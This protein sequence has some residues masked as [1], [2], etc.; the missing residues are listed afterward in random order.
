MA[1]K[2]I[3]I[4]ALLLIF[5]I[6][7]SPT[8][9]V[10]CGSRFPTAVFSL[11]GGPD[12]P[13]QDFL[14]GE[15][16]ILQPD[17][18]S[19]NLVPAY[20]YLTGVGLNAEEQQALLGETCHDANS[21]TSEKA[22][23]PEDWVQNW[24]D[25]RGRIKAAGAAPPIGWH[26][27]GSSS[28]YRAEQK[29]G[30]FVHY[31][32]CAEDAFKTAIATL[33]E[34]IRVFG[35]QGPEILDWIKAQDAVFSNCS[36]GSTIPSPAVPDDNPTLKADRA[37]QIAAAH[38]YAGDFEQAEK[39]F[40]EISQDNTSPWR[41]IAPYL[42]ARCQVR[43]GT[44]KG[45]FQKVE[46]A[47]MS[48]AEASLRAILENSNLSQYHKPAEDLL[49]YVVTR[50]RP[51]EQVHQT[52]LR[53]STKDAGRKMRQ[54][55][56]DFRYLLMNT[57]PDA[58]RAAREL[59]DLTDWV[60]TFQN[61]TPDSLEHSIERWEKTRSQ[62]WLIAAI[63]KIPAGHPK[64]QIVQA[65]A[66]KLHSTEPGYQTAI[67]HSL[68]LLIDSGE[69]DVAR[70]RLDI[71]LADA[72][73]K[74]TNSARNLLLGLRLQ[75]SNSL[76]EFL[77][78]SQR[79]P[80]TVGYGYDENDMDMDEELK[81]EYAGQKMLDDDAVKILNGCL[82]HSIL[83]EI[84]SKPIFPQKIRKDI[85]LSAWMRAVILENEKA[86]KSSIAVLSSI[87]PEMQEQ[88]AGYITAT[89]QARKFVASYIILKNPGMKPFISAGIGRTTPLDKIDNFRDNWWCELGGD[90]SPLRVKSKLPQGQAGKK[91]SYPGFLTKEQVQKMEQEMQALEK[92][93]TAPN[94]LAGLVLPWAKAHQAD[95]RVPE[96]L[97]LLVKA[98]RFGCGNEETSGYSKAAFKLLHKRYPE[99]MWA[100]KTPYHY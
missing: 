93:K 57:G 8:T 13:A 45:G 20:R 95:P 96:A 70:K 97:H 58:Q 69:Q 33:N 65:E 81:Q 5:T 29:D 26:S 31:L 98:T 48:R 12:G 99:S 91:E 71:L 39:I 61:Q 11:T 82:P 64:H 86:T 51:A 37:Y 75:L 76:D 35:P 41:A 94:Y 27:R 28:I 87:A 2:E 46:M 47:S 63:S 42:A 77:L 55:L 17:F 52:A 18:R 59:D 38:F 16:G 25:A 23:Q 24:L 19:Y 49:G 68:R 85:A 40:I 54:Y 56:Q 83:V 60:L 21:S 9:S 1:I 53:L 15:L 100:K 36:Q 14:R 4:I 92:T 66:D 10:P 62:A 43:N 44:L 79:T 74:L 6:L 67:Y 88:V 32:N 80:A 78:Y 84:A 7:M 89:P 90:R 30:N 72:N 50:L 34:R 22:R 3:R 73:L